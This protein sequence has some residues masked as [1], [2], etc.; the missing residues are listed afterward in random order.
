MALSTKT[1]L[2]T[3]EWAK[4]LS[5][6]RNP[7]IGNS[8]EPALTSAQMVMDTMLSPPFSFWWNNEELVFTCN[9]TLA[10]GTLTNIAI[11]SGVLTV[12]IPNSFVVGSLVLPSAIGTTTALNGQLLE[13]LTASSSQFTANTTVPD[14]AS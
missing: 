7:V 8:L 2:N 4:K 6:A 5:Y 9:P 13:I 1:I 3:I 12:T 10:T 11:V 14:V